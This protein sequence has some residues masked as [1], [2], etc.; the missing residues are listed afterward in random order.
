MAS[1]GGSLGGLIIP[2]FIAYFLRHDGFTQTVIFLAC[3]W[4]QSCVVGV[5]LKPPPLSKCVARVPDDV[6]MINSSD[7]EMTPSFKTS[8]SR[9]PD[10][11]KN[12]WED[13]L[14][15][16]NIEGSVDREESDEKNN[17]W[18]IVNKIRR[19]RY[20]FLGNCQIV[21]YYLALCLSSTAYF[22]WFLF[23][24]SY[25]LENGL[26]KS[27]TSMCLALASI[28]E[29]VIRPIIGIF[30]T[31]RNCPRDKPLTVSICSIVAG[32]STFAVSL[33][34]K[35]YVIYAYGVVFGSVSGLFLSL[36]APMMADHVRPEQLG[37]MTGLFGVFVA[38]GVG[39][40]S[41]ILGKY[42]NISNNFPCIS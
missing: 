27:E 20:S 11:Y 4:I 13:V 16:D 33:Y 40:G 14:D 9:K 38:S 34:I 37:S 25:T 26:T 12:L 23:L 1:S 36:S 21:M 29:G 6:T 28:S 24:P 41:P 8:E 30:L 32:L 5:I 18:K 7:Q 19:S 15:E 17:D 22:N 31:K 35:P 42:N 39:I 2:I 3:A 10:K